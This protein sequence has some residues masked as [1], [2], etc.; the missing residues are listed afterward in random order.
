MGA[1][2]AYSLYAVRSLCPRHISAAAVTTC[3]AM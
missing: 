3:G 2:L 1:G